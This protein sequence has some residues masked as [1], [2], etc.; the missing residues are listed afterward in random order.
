METKVIKNSLFF[1]DVA[2][3][4]TSGERVKI[5]AKGNSMLPFIRDGLDYIILEMP[6]PNSFKKGR[7]LLFTLNDNKY[8]VHRV[9]SVN[10]DHLILQGD[11]NLSILESCTRKKVIAEATAVIRKGKTIKRGSLRWN[12]YRY[13][14]PKGRFARRVL[15]GARRRLL[16]K[17][18]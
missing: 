13:L 11:G 15:L 1:T 12:L 4:V 10:K 14:W 6:N 17:N 3:V 18:Q 2:H 8:L 7:L 9:K 5:R 16:T